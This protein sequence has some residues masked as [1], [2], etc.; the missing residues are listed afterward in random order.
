MLPGARV[1]D[2]IDLGEKWI[3]CP[4]SWSTSRSTVSTCTYT[5]S[6]TTAVV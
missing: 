6:K 1:F 2:L 3:D 4:A 5:T